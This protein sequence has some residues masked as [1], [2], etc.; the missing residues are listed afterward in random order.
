MQGDP[1]LNDMLCD[2]RPISTQRKERYVVLSKG[3]YLSNNSGVYLWPFA[4]EL[5]LVWSNEIMSR[6][7]KGEVQLDAHDKR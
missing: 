7:A 6:Q 5:S 4:S 2:L 3:R 1:I